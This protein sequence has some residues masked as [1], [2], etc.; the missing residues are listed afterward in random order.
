[1]DF[2]WIQWKP[3]DITAIADAALAHKKAAYEAVKAIPTRERTFAN[4]IAALERASDGLGDVQRTLAL[5][6]N[7]HPD[8]PLR[9]AAQK[10]DERI[11][12]EDIAMEYDR[13]IWRAVQEWMAHGELL[14]SADQK[15]AD[16]LIRDL[17]RTGFDLPDAQFTRLQ[18]IEKE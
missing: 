7:V 12:H 17:R 9:K 14:K 5:I 8:A 3:G 15:L 18:Q 2:S 4:T 1:M 13:D 16:D 11:D 6:L 10:V